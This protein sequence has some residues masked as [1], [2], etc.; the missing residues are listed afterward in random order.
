MLIDKPY[1]RE[2][3]AKSGQNR[4][5]EVCAPDKIVREYIRIYEE[6]GRRIFPSNPSVAGLDAG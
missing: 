4:V 5:V 3:L 1:L 6:Q 2:R